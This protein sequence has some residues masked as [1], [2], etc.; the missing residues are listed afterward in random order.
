ML[1]GAVRLGG[2]VCL[3]L[4]TAVPE[5]T[6]Q[7]PAS[8]TSPTDPDVDALTEEFS[9]VFQPIPPCLPPERAVD[10]RIEVDPPPSPHANPHAVKAP[11]W[12]L[13]H[14]AKSRPPCTMGK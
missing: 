9:S 1:H 6:P 11:P 2:E 14:G 13:R 3:T 12:Q 10:H 7:D 5:P 8:P 4:V